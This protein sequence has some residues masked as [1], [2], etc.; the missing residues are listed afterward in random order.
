MNGYGMVD[1]D[2]F[3]HRYI[4]CGPVDLE[5]R[6]VQRTKQS[7]P[8]SYDG[9]VVMRCGPNSEINVCEY[10]DRLQQWDGAKYDRCRKEHMAGV[11]WDTA[12]PEQ[13]TAFLRDYHGDPSIRL[14]AVMEWCNQATG[15]P[16]WSLHYHAD[17]VAK[18]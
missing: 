9:F 11:R 3:A 5:G 2:T 12:K 17:K 18:P 1:T 7:H 10:T 14:I 13:I 8:Y 16:T 4:G 6:P 15:Y